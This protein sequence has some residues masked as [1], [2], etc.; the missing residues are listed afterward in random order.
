MF[1]PFVRQAVAKW[2]PKPVAGHPNMTPSI[3]LFPVGVTDYFGLVMDKKHLVVPIK[4]VYDMPDLEL[5]H[6]KLERLVEFLEEKNINWEEALLGGVDYYGNLQYKTPGAM[7]SYLQ[8]LVV[9]AA[10]PKAAPDIEKKL[11]FV[12]K[13]LDESKSE[14]GNGFGLLPML[15]SHSAVC[16]VQKEIGVRLA[17]SSL[18]DSIKSD[19]DVNDPKNGILRLLYTCR[20]MC[21]ESLYCAQML[22]GNTSLNSHPLM[23][24]R[25]ALG[26]KIG[27]LEVPDPDTRNNATALHYEECFFER[28]YT[29]EVMIQCILK[30]LNESPRKLHYSSVVS[31]LQYHRPNLFRDDAEEFLFHCFDS[32][33]LFTMGAVAWILFQMGVLTRAE[34]GEIDEKALFPELSD[35]TLDEIRKSISDMAVDNSPLQKSQ[36]EIQQEL[37]VGMDALRHQSC[38]HVENSIVKSK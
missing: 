30:A 18:M 6:V 31:F 16:N 13:A 3:L 34:G 38:E 10:S 7:K 19:C 28:F 8:A 26:M 9:Y 22:N 36:E 15:A 24:Y 17:Y 37:K 25:N 35:E 29:I 1:K 14:N 5:G 23:G 33:G 32:D 20:E 12:I 21:L 4:E 11:K 27:L 2:D